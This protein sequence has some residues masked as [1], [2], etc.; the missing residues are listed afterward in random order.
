[1]IPDSD[2]ELERGLEARLTAGRNN[3]ILGTAKSP[4][5]FSIVVAS[6]Q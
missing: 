4:F 3:L 1:M 2:I 5:R 6:G